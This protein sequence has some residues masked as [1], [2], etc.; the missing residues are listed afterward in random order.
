MPTSKGYAIKQ[1][2]RENFNAETMLVKRLGEEI[3]KSVGCMKRHAVSGPVIEDSRET[4]VDVTKSEGKKE[5]E[6]SDNE[7]MGWTKEE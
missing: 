3:E 2:K 6:E 7:S 1:V 4:G 5:E